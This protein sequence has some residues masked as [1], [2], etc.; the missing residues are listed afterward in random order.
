MTKTFSL[1]RKNVLSRPSSGSCTAP[2]SASFHPVRVRGGLDGGGDGSALGSRASVCFRFFPMAMREREREREIIRVLM[3]RRKRE[4]N[5]CGF[6]VFASR[7]FSSYFSVLILNLIV[8]NSLDEYVNLLKLKFQI[9]PTIIKIV[10]IVL[11]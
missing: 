2:A 10:N 8:I 9:T 7:V 3:E 6:R 11:K 1:L 5:G 4:G